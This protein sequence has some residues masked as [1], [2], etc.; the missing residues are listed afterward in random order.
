[1]INGIAVDKAA[2]TACAATGPCP[3]RYVVPSLGVEIID[4]EVSGERSAVIDT[5]TYSPRTV[6]LARSPGPHVPKGWRFVSFGG[7]SVAAPAA[8]Y[9]QTTSNWSGGCGLDIVMEETGVTL[10]SGATSILP[11]CPDQSPGGG[12]VQPPV[13]GVIVD[14]GIYGPINSQTTFGSCLE[15]HGLRVCPSASDSYGLLVAAVHL[16]GRSKPVAVEIGLAGTGVTARTILLSLR[17]A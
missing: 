8:W 9:V 4:D 6:V 16:P 5:L 15:I 2:E 11:S 10:D 1:V 7:I 12:P 14:P 17:A 3:V 13:D